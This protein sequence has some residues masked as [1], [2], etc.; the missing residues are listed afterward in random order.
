MQY[1]HTCNTINIPNKI[2]LGVDIFKGMV[3]RRESGLQGV[4]STSSIINAM[5]C[6][7]IVTQ[8]VCTFRFQSVFPTGFFYIHM[9]LF[10]LKYSSDTA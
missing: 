9:R 3:K 7:Q 10:Y 1:A 2:T 5:Q 4:K 8:I 6:T